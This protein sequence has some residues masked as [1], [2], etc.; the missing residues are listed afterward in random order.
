MLLIPKE[1]NEV[2]I[3]SKNKDLEKLS[4][5]SKVMDIGSYRSKI[6]IQVY[7]TPISKV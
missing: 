1:L 5:L 4:N 6:Q 2:I 7:L 3:M